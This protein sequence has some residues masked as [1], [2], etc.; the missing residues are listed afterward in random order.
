MLGVDRKKPI[1]IKNKTKVGF[2]CY[3]LSAASTSVLNP[4]VQDASHFFEVKA[5]PLV[6]T[7]GDESRILFPVHPTT[8]QGRFF[9]FNTLHRDAPEG[10]LASLCLPVA[11]AVARESDVVCHL[12]IQGVPALFA[13]LFARLLG[14]PVVAINRTTLPHAERKRSLAI[15]TLKGWILR[16]SAAIVSQTPPTTDTLVE[17][18]G[19]PRDT[20]VVAPWDGGAS[21]FAPILEQQNNTTREELRASLGLDSDSYV[22]LYSG[23]VTGYKGLDVLITSLGQLHR[24]GLKAVLLLVGGGGKARGMLES[25]KEQAEREGVSDRLKILGR[26]AWTTLARVYLAADVFVLPTRR[27]VWPKVLVEAALAGLPLVTTD[28]C[29]AAGHMVRPGANGYV[30]PV[31]DAAA[32]AESLRRLSDPATRS[33]LGQASRLIAGE[34][35]ELSETQSAGIVEAVLTAARSRTR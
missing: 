23:A 11:W 30:V 33:A 2:L 32:L 35:R 3:N 31:N 25:L 24:W 5:Y 28:V 26:L 1:M 29:G 19:V 7:G 6:A 22:L 8:F 16:N 10:T 13:T 12:G 21:E 15:R 17:V 14:R 18:Y 9:Q 34:Y 27:D 4:L 20:I